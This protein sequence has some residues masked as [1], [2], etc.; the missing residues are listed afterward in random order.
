VNSR[1]GRTFETNDFDIEIIRDCIQKRRRRLKML[2]L[3]FYRD[4][5]TLISAGG[6]FDHWH[7]DSWLLSDFAKRVVKEVDKSE[8]IGPHL[9]ES[10]VL[11]PIPPATLSGGA[12]ALLTIY[13]LHDKWKYSSLMLGD[14]CT[15]FLLE[16]AGDKDVTVVL[17]HPIRLPKDMTDTV[18]FSS[19]DIYVDNYSDFMHTMI[20][21]HA[22]PWGG[23]RG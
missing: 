9:I 21:N 7:E 14:N 23:E 5:K 22:K 13:N 8:I 2:I 11:G 1:Y 6:Y 17:E 18:Y 19:I 3:E 20:Q 15:K 16:I 4:E 10:Q 12:K